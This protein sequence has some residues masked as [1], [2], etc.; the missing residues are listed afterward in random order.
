[1]GYKKWIGFFLLIMLIICCVTVWTLHST[2]KLHSFACDRMQMHFTSDCQVLC[3][4]VS[5]STQGQLAH[6]TLNAIIQSTA[7][8]L[9]SSVWV[10]KFSTSRQIIKPQ[11]Q[12]AC[13]ILD[14]R[15]VCQWHFTFTQ[16]EMIKSDSQSN[17]C[18]CSHAI[19]VMSYS[20]HLFCC[21]IASSFPLVSNLRSKYQPFSH[22]YISFSC[23]L[24]RVVYF[25]LAAAA[26]LWCGLTIW[27]VPLLDLITLAS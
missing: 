12:W 1:M 19:L 3:A 10:H 26:R 13:L 6:S 17:Y 20:S 2:S 15:S 23:W 7:Y 11:G 9:P 8:N 16:I 4:L 25:S 21:I 18:S 14:I 22:L 27:L 24:S 5:T